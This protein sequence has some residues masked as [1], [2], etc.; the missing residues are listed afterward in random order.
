MGRL[1]ANKKMHNRAGL[2]NEELEAVLPSSADQS[3]ETSRPRAEREMRTAE[4]RS[5]RTEAMTVGAS[6]FG[7]PTARA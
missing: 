2:G 5:A 1:A 4:R 6:A 7:S 3:P